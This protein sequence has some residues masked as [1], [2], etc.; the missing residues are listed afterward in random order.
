MHLE[1]AGCSAGAR[2]GNERVAGA[3]RSTRLFA[4]LPVADLCWLAAETVLAPRENADVV[5]RQ[6]DAAD[7]LFIIASGHVGVFLGA[8]G[9]YG[10]LAGTAGRGELLG[11]AA[12]IGFPTYPA[13]SQMLS[14]GELVTVP[15][16]AVR[17][18]MSQHFEM[19]LAL[20]GE[21]SMRIRRQVRE[22]MDLKMKTAPQRLA[23]HLAMLTPVQQGPAEVRLPYEK[24]LLATQ[25]GMQ[26]ETLS[27][28][29]MR[30]QA[31]GVSNGAGAG[32][33]SLRDVALLRRYASDD[34]GID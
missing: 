24:K 10:C 30:L 28:A 21:M 22:I 26:P 4:R 23:G 19:V 16:A 5:F 7:T 34:A 31:L 1:K 8:P 9:D 12:I 13:S 18:L 3:L 15:A 33:F 11:E 25:L 6:G 29:L 32:A 27:R 2:G 17:H 14:A 20:M